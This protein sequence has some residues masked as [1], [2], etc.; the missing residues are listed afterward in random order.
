MTGTGPRLVV[1]DSVVV[2]VVLEVDALPERGSDTYVRASSTYA[3]GGFNVL[4]AASRLG[5]PGVYAGAF[6]TGPFAKIAIDALLREGVEVALSPNL[7]EDTGFVV[8]IVDGSGERTFL[9]SNGAESRLTTEQLRGVAL[10]NDDVVYFSGYV[11]LHESNE[12]A[13]LDIVQR[14]PDT[15]RLIFDPGPLVTAIPDSSLAAVFAR[16]DWISCNAHEAA[17][18]SQLGDARSAATALNARMARGGAIVRTGGDG[19]VVATNDGTD[20]VAGFSVDAIDS[21]GAG[22]C[23][24]GAFMAFTIQGRGYVESAR[25]ANAAAA[26]SV[27]KRG[28]ATGPTRDELE[29]FLRA[30]SF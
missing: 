14:L 11:L 7:D 1:V 22:D 27:T 28:P 6:G 15:A 24:V 19:C 4:A 25:L 2:D 20:V 21:N 5:L 30:H 9:T 26:A 23:H 17:L 16:A 3:G 18:L 8:A 10:R 29:G 13:L 12:V